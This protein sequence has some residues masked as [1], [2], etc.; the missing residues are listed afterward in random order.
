MAKETEMEFEGTVVEVLP[1]AQFKV[2]LE[3]GV[4]INAHVSGKIRMHYIRI[5]PGDKV[6]IVISPYDMT[7]GRITYRKI[8]K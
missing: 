7:R 8:N 1:N 6:T 4:V 2:K 5:L 3:N